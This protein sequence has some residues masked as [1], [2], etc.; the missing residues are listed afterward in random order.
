[1]KPSLVVRRWSFATT[2]RRDLHL[3][4]WALHQ[5]LRLPLLPTTDD[6]RPTTPSPV[7]RSVAKS[8]DLSGPRSCSATRNEIFRPRWGGRG[9]EVG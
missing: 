1:M 7:S 2:F 3:L 4:S 6:Q 8:S 5:R 9:P